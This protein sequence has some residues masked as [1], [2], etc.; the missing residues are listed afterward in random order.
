MKI[1][2]LLPRVAVSAGTLGTVALVS[3]AMVSLVMLTGCAMAML[4]GAASAGGS[5]A[6]QD[7]RSASRIAADDAIT[8]A[9]RSKL[10]A[11]PALKT[12]NLSVDTHDGVVTLRGQVAKV[13][14]RNAAQLDAR[15]VKGV[16]AVQNL[17]TVR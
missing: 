10:S 5:G 6:S 13:G 8:T 3:L 9:V 11:D 12:L 15:A 17:L 2:P 7:R 4:S 16:K 14:Q 1:E